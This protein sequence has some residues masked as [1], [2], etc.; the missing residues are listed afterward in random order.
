MALESAKFTRIHNK[1]G[2]DLS[3]M[4]TAFNNNKHLDVIDFPAESAMLFQIQKMQEELEYLRT[5][6]ALNKA[7][8]SLA[9]PT[10]SISFGDLIST[11]SRGKTTYTI[12]LTA[13]KDGV[14]KSTTLTL[15]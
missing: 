8:V 9:G 5:E 3:A 11:T 15:R 7:K 10:T 2:S 6:I 12:V 1:T 4:Q 14:S 13:T